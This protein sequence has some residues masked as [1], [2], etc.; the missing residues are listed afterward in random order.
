MT[1][2]GVNMPDYFLRM[3]DVL[4]RTGLTRSPLYRMINKG[5]FPSPVKI[6]VKSIAWPESSVN[7]WI[8]DRKIGKPLDAKTQ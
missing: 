7:Q 3:K 6:G 2:P 5:Q 1:K 8:E 4:K